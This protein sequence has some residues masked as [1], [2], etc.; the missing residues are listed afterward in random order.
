M[1]LTAV[2]FPAH[3]DGI[4]LAVCGGMCAVCAGRVGSAAWRVC[5]SGCKP[6]VDLLLG[7]TWLGIAGSTSAS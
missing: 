2:T 7:A 1:Q 6:A 4:T 5:Q 3:T